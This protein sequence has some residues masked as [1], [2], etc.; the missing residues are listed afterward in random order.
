MLALGMLVAVSYA[1]AV[2][3]GG[4]VWDDRVITEAPPIRNWNG[5]WSIWL[6]PS[7]LEF[8]EGHYWPLVYTTFWLEHKLWGFAP[9]GYHAVNVLLHA[10][11]T[12]LLWHVLLRLAVPGAWVVA[13]VFAVHPLHVESVAWVL[14]RKDVL[15]ALFYL[16][17]FWTWDRFVDEPYAKGRMRRYVSTLA[18]FVLGMLS[19]S[20]VVTL[21]AALLIRQWWKR[22]RVVTADL[23]PLV[24]FFVAGLAIAAA[25]TS[26]YRSKEAVFFDYSPI[27]RVLIAAH[28]LWFYVGKLL[29][30]AGLAVIYP[31]WEVRVADPLAWGYVAAAVTAGAAF[32]FLRHRIGRGPLAGALFFAVTLAPVLGL[33]DFGYMQFSFVADRYQYLAGI[34]VITVIVG[35]AAACFLRLVAPSYS[36]VEGFHSDRLPTAAKWGMVGVVSVFLIV[37]GALTWRQADIYRDNVTFYTHILAHNPTARSAQY[38]LGNALITAQRPEEALAA[39]RIAT[40]QQPDSVDAHSNTGRALM[41]LGRLDEAA[42]RLRHALEMDPRHKVSLQNLALVRVRQ[43]HPEEALDIYRRL[44]EIDPRHVGGHSG[45]GIALHYLGR[46]D[47]AL[48]SVDRALA[49]DPT[50]AEALVNR[51]LMPQVRSHAEAGR[52]L[53]EQERFDEAEQHLR[54]VLQIDPAYTTALQNLA[55]LQLRQQRYDEALTLYRRLVEMNPDHAEAHS[56][57]GVALYSLGSVEEALE[58]L[59][60]ALSLDPTLEEARTNREAMRQSALASAP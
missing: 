5:L 36:P 1:P 58:S 8:W 55:L 24:P 38:N 48:Q 2:L 39:F 11:N 13:A 6:S 40:A 15:S 51:E 22:G 12:L 19:K 10:A 34:G 49:L 26:F 54:Y 28:A 27:E 41:D 3:W 21:P 7:D 59:D 18:L 53:M 9:A 20:I 43:H 50:Y 17:A 23:V 52:A 32:W 45:M 42:D 56:G 33:V 29:W 37:L 25:D 4:F 16:A 60:R 44:L 30:P 47:E 31:H 46:T 35:S 57:L 14:E